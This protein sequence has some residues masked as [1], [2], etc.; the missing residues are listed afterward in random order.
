M[1][2]TSLLSSG[3]VISDELPNLSNFICLLRNN[4]KILFVTWGY[5]K[6]QMRLWES[7]LSI[8]D[9]GVIIKIASI[10]N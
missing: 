6:D 5:R 8:K 4:L 1:L 9:Y 3:W 7:K 10:Q 2:S